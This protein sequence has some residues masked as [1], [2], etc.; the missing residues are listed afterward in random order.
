MKKFILQHWRGEFSLPLA[1]WG[2]SVLFVGLIRI[3]A[4]VLTGVL[5]SSSTSLTS[6]AWLLFG[7]YAFTF[8]IVCWSLV[9]TWRSATRY[10]LEKKSSLWS[11]LAKLAI[12]LG[13]LQ[14][15]STFLIKEAPVLKVMS[16]Y[17]MGS[18]TST[19]I[20]VEILDDGKTIKL[21]GMFGNGSFNSFKSSLDR[22]PNINRVFLSS[23]GGLFKEVSLIAEE[24]LQKRLDTYVEDKCESFC[25]I[26]FLSGYNR[27]S[28]PN[29]KIGF[30]SPT[31]KGASHLDEDLHSESKK[32]YAKLRVSKEFIDKIYSTPNSDVWYPTHKELIDAG[33]VNK[34]T[35]GGETNSLGGFFNKNKNELYDAFSKIELYSSYEK[36]FPGTINKVIEITMPMA[37]AGKTDSEILNATRAYIVTFTLKAVAKSTPE[38]RTRFISLAAKQSREASKIGNEACYKLLTTTLDVTKAFPKELVDEELNLIKDAL[39]SSFIAPKGYRE[40][41]YEQLLQ[42]ALSSLSD[43]ELSTVTSPSL[44]NKNNCPAITKFYEAIDNLPR[45]NKDIVAY[46]LFS[47]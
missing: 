19:R 2:I 5:E 43:S 13:V 30:H 27:F 11:G 26:V 29:A 37:K 42:T 1:Y 32:L 8:V 31:I 40:V 25:T 18:N 34:V 28:T 41:L 46:G 38:I 4:E 7:F 3:L 12:V 45:Q 21:S 10:S 23:N 33:I 20:T 36:K 44:N 39:N 35:L 17:L 22:N 24:I 14:I 9:G 16:P 47:S 15:S 6:T